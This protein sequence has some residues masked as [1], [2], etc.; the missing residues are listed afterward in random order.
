[1]LN[2]VRPRTVA[3]HVKRQDRLKDKHRHDMTAKVAADLNRIVTMVKDRMVTSYL[4][5]KYNLH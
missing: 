5:R 3:T 4:N 1:M 2:M